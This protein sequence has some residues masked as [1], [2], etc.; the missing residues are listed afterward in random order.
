MTESKK[1]VIVWIHGGA[2]IFGGIDYYEADYIMEQDVVLVTIQYRLNVF[3][4]LSTEDSSAPGNYGSLDQ[5]AALKWIQENIGAFG[6]DPDSV[7][8]FGMSA[9]GA[10]VHYL[11][12][13]PLTRNLYKNAVSFAK[14]I[15]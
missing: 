11:T 5:V 6:G 15:R 9:G 2:F 4:F 8:I 14:N 7:T 10:S 3:G 12:L 13:S 1:Q